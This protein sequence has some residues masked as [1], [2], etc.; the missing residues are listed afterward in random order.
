MIELIVAMAVKFWM[1]TILIAF[2]LIGWAINF[3]DKRR[4]NKLKF[5]Y[6]EYPH[7]QPLK[8]STKRYRLL[9]KNPSPRTPCK[10]Y[11][12]IK[13][14][15]SRES[16]KSLCALFNARCLYEDCPISTKYPLEICKAVCL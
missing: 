8:I 1:W 3:F 10:A 13:K 2:I 6:T 16:Y 11:T 7:M 9:F 12:I 5:T 14:Y 15:L 4:P